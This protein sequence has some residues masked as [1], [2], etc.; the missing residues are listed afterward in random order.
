MKVTK[1]YEQQCNI[2]SGCQQV[3][4]LNASLLALALLSLLT[5]YF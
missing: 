1:G 3:K 5:V 4:A 2:C